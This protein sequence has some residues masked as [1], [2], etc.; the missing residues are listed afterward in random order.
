MLRS[1]CPRCGVD[2]VDRFLMMDACNCCD[3]MTWQDEGPAR[4]GTAHGTARR[5][6]GYCS[7]DG[8][9]GSYDSSETCRHSDAQWQVSI[10]SLIE[11][12]RPKRLFYIS[13]FASFLPPSAGGKPSQQ[14]SQTEHLHAKPS[15]GVSSSNPYASSTGIS[16]NSGTSISGSSCSAPRE[17]F[18]RT[19]STRKDCQWDAEAS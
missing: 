6:L 11:V 16:S 8:E 9:W 3:D 7:R 19:G 17:R 18:G 2:R 10:S 15:H 4:Q 14:T 12:D 13:V 5:H 1:P